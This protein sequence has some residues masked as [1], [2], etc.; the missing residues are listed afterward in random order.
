MFLSL[1]IGEQDCIQ[2]ELSQSLVKIITTEPRLENDARYI[3]LLTLCRAS[4]RS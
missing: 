3:R 2:N 1:L 4:G